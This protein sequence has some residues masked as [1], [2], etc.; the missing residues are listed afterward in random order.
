[1][2]ARIQV[3]G[4]MNI[5]HSSQR[6]TARSGRRGPVVGTL[7]TG[8]ARVELAAVGC[9]SMRLSPLAGATLNQCGGVVAKACC[10]VRIRAYNDRHRRKVRGM[11]YQTESAHVDRGTARRPAA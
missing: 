7:R 9:I 5:R 3:A 2:A 8:A 6:R 10:R 11:E 4:L 1:M